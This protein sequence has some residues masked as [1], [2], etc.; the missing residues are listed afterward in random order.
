MDARDFV[1]LRDSVPN[2]AILD[3][4]NA[5]I[6]S[7]TGT[8]GTNG[9]PNYVYKTNVLPTRAFYN[10]S[11]SMS[12]ETLTAIKL[13]T[14]MAAIGDDSFYYC[15]GLT[16]IIIPPTATSIGEWAFYGCTGLPSITIPHSVTKIGSNAFVYCSALINVNENNPNF[17]SSEGVLFN[18]SKSKLIQCPISVYGNYDI[19]ITVDSIGSKAF[20]YCKNISSISIPLAVT[21]IDDY[22][23]MACNFSTIEIPESVVAI[24]NYAFYGCSNLMSIKT[25]N[26]VP[27]DLSSS[28]AV[29]YGVNKTSCTLNVP[30]GSKLIYQMAAQWK[31]FENIV[32]KLS[33][34]ITSI[35]DA[36]ILP[37]PNPTKKHFQISGIEG[38]ASVKLLDLNGKVLLTKQIAGNEYIQLNNIAPGMYILKII[39]SNATFERKLIK[40]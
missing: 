3:I 4:S 9:A 33:T 17:A 13:P 12:K 21:V 24:K 27:I 11:T 37:Y 40:K 23:F 1:T 25:N 7:Y 35:A 22:A 19:P 28:I 29:F 6:S 34:N 16:S 31:D 39:T 2:L 18:K 36:S 15:S 14:S 30:K 26:I 10:P 8:N 38:K 20:W 5:L 32:E